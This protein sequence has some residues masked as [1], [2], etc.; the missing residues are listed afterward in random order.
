[1][2]GRKKRED[3]LDKRIIEECAMTWWLE[4]TD[5]LQYLL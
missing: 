1:M 4:Y 2:R 5:T 3:T